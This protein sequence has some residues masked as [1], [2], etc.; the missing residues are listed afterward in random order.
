MRAIDPVTITTTDGQQRKLL[1]SMGGIRRLKQRM[2]VKNFGELMA[3]D[4]E[5]ISV[6]M[7]FEALLDKGN[8]TEETLAD[9]LP[10]HLEDI[11]ATVVKLLGASMPE[12]RP[13]IAEPKPQ[14]I[15]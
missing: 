14:A 13:T 11:A 7:I 4:T 10:A 8:L 2:G 15:Q 3:L 6:P 5:A 12:A 1:L 9:I